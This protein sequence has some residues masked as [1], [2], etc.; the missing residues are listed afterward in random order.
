MGIGV[1]M[2]C[3]VSIQSGDS[4]FTTLVLDLV[5]VLPLLSQDQGSSGYL[6]ID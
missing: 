1:S 4:I 6:K 5:L 3:L 2:H